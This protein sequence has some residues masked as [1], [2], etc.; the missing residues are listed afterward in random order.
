MLLMLD[1]DFVAVVVEVK[2]RAVFLIDLDFNLYN[3]T[4]KASNFLK[5]NLISQNII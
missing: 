5:L 4:I 2:I 1:F 3:I